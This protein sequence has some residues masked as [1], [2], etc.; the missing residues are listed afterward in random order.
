MVQVPL[1]VRREKEE[2]SNS[3]K[4]TNAIVQSALFAN[5]FPIEDRWA[6]LNSYE[7]KKSVQKRLLNR[8]MPLASLN[9]ADK[10]IKGFYDTLERVLD[11]Y[12]N[13]GMKLT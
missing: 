9:E 13:Y 6:I 5:H 4:S 12:W 2:H 10:T 8:I 1:H 7:M 3:L 11:L